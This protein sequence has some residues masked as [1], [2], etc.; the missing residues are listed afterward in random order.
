MID[1]SKADDRLPE[2]LEKEVPYILL[3]GVR[4]Y[5]EK[6]CRRQNNIWN[7]VPAYFKEQRNNLASNTH[8][9]QAYLEDKEKSGEFTFKTVRPDEYK[10]EKVYY[11]KPADFKKDF[12]DWCRASGKQ[13]PNWNRDYYNVVFMKKGIFESPTRLRRAW[14]P[15]NAIKKTLSVWFYGFAYTEYIEEEL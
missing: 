7:M 14:P 12:M 8:A 2:K 1:P 6:I 13:V 4:G 15:N 11:I 10:N 5:L 9:L 3:S